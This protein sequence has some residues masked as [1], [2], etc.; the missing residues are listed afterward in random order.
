MVDG[1]VSG[2]VIV[3]AGDALPLEAIASSLERDLT[4]RPGW[5]QTQ[6]SR[7]HAAGAPPLTDDFAPTDALISR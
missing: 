7:D 1:G 5:R 2:N 4:S 6:S 3:V